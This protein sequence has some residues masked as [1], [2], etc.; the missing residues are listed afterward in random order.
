MS[1]KN[2]SKTVQFKIQSLDSLGQGVSK[3]NGEIVFIPKTLP[4]E[5]GIAKIT[6]SKKKVSFGSL[7]NLTKVSDQRIESECPHYA[8][9]GGCHYL[10]TSY[11]NEIDLKKQAMI[12]IFERQHAIEIGKK[13]EILSSQSRFGYRNRVQLHYDVNSNKLGF[14]TQE[15]KEILE[16]PNCLLPDPE[17][18][19]QVSMLYKNQSWKQY[20]KKKKQG[21]IEIYHRDGKVDLVANERYAFSGFSQVNIPMND[22][23]LS[24]IENKFKNID[25]KTKY[26]LDI[27]GG[28]G[29]LTANLGVETLVVDA[30]PE[31]FI[32]LR[33]EQQEYRRIDLFKDNSLELL[34]KYVS[35]QPDL[36]MVDPPRSGFKQLDLFAQEFKPEHIIYV[37]CNPQSLA[38]D[39][40]NLGNSYE[41]EK[42]FMVDFFP[43]TKH[44]ESMVFLKRI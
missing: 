17:V 5:E 14:R 30:T 37:S 10:H 8:L 33:N 12:D 29:N 19:K 1:N 44:F 7:Q 34:K 24:H 2:K 26:A 9:C 11:D 38:R 6:A 42:V 16:V 35:K 22:L 18:A 39:L 4:G 43:G 36:L 21:H 31:K 15:T 23:L 25:F 40:K 20:S 3:E 41:L 27:F 28:N 32:N 13:L